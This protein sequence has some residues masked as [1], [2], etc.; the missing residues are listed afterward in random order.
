M[1]PKGSPISKLIIAWCHKKT[2]HAERGM[3]LNE[4]RTSE[5]WI[6]CTN[7]ATRKFIHYCVVCRSLRWKLG[8]FDRLQKEPPFTYCGVDLFG[9]FV[10]CSK[11]KELKRYGVMF[12][13]LCSR[14]IHIEVAHSLDTDSFL[15]TLRRFMG[16]RGN[17]R[18]MRSDNGSNF[19]EA[20]KELGK[21]FQEMNHSRI[22][23]YL[24]MHG[25][26]WIT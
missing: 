11:R 3:T 14:A 8:E 22:N 10:I 24:Q 4:I 25:A 6:V 16:R 9:L 21:S 18:Q 7:S 23:E 26:D 5:F 20:V 1:L 19:V 12:T 17:I 2:G 13:C 15:L